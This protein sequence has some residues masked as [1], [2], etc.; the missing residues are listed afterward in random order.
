MTVVLKPKITTHKLNCMSTSSCVERRIQRQQ[1]RPV[2]FPFGAAACYMP[3]ST[4]CLTRETH[5]SM[6][7]RTS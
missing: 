7:S 6:S 5:P 4:H 3:F 2:E 1:W